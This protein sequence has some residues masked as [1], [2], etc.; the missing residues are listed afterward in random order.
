MPG[1]KKAELIEGVV[2]MASPLRFK[3]HAEPHGRLI[4]WLGVYQLLILEYKWVL[5][6]Q[7]A[8]ISRSESQPDGCY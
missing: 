1:L 4:T 5:S 7:F 3:F 8:W 6:R 2:Y